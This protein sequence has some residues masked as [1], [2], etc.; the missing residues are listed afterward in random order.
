MEKYLRIRIRKSRTVNAKLA[1]TRAGKT[2]RLVAA[3]AAGKELRYLTFQPCGRCTVYCLCGFPSPQEN[4]KL[5]SSILRLF[6]HDLRV[7]G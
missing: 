7:P 5:I 1:L 3:V 6:Y 2:A 4:V